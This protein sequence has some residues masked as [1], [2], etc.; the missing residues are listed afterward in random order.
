[1]NIEFSALDDFLKVTWTPDKKCLYFGCPVEK[2]FK[3]SLP[4]NN[5]NHN[6]DMSNPDKQQVLQQHQQ[7]VNTQNGKVNIP[8]CTNQ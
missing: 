3:I 4:P 5:D 7:Q 1:M 6:Q 8:Q 2:T